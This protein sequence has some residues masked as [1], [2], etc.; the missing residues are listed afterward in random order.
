[1][2]N[3]SKTFQAFHLVLHDENFMYTIDLLHVAIDVYLRI[4]S[5]LGN[6]EYNVLN[7]ASEFLHD[8][9]EWREH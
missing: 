3:E 1:M 8:V 7:M 4:C 6:G 5:N 9:T 2:L